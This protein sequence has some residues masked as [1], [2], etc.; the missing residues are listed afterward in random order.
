[1]FGYALGY[2][3]A[4]WLEGKSVPQAID[5]LPKVLTAANLTEYRHEVSDP[6]SVFADRRKR[7]QYLKLYGNICFDT[8]DRY[9]N[10]PWSSD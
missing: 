2:F 1:V 10:F 5:I 9:L 7:D 4:D 3:A 6:A 8:R